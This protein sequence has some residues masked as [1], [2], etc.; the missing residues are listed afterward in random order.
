MTSEG[1]CFPKVGTFREVSG[2]DLNR[3]FI[4]FPGVSAKGCGLHLFEVYLSSLGCSWPIGLK[5]ISVSAEDSLPN[6]API[7]PIHGSSTRWDPV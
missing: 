2:E 7:C 3:I 4:S 1:L 6:W 5:F